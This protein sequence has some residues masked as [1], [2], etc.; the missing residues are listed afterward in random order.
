MGL[1]VTGETERKGTHVLVELEGLIHLAREAVDEETALAVLPAVAVAL[2]GE[3]SAHGVLEQL[4][5]DLHGHDLTLADVLADH[6]AILGPFPVL[7]RAEQVSS[8]AR[9]GG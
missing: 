6:L 7:L 1:R 3:S 2:L 8:Y 4:D 9:R 5:G